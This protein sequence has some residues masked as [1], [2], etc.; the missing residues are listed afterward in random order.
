MVELDVLP[1]YSGY[2]VLG[3]RLGSIIGRTDLIGTT[4]QFD[5]R[6]RSIKLTALQRADWH[7]PTFLGGPTMCI[8]DG[9]TADTVR[10]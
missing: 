3:T 4:E 2:V 5:L 8:S 6:H 7:L 9:P 10:I 1:L